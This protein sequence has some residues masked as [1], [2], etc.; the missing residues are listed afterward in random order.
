MAAVSG[1]EIQEGKKSGWVNGLGVELTSGLSKISRLICFVCV[2]WREG[3][4]EDA[5]LP[6]SGPSAS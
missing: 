4:Q 6:W 3:V 5:F 1:V 2:W